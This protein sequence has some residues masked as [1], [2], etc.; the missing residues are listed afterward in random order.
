MFPGVGVFNIV[1]W[2]WTILRAVNPRYWVM[3]LVNEGTHG[4][5]LLG[6]IVLCITGSPHN[7]KKKKKH[8][9]WFPHNMHPEP[10]LVVV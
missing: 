10:T 7:A 9:L 1:H 2:D 4:W 3:F 8:N 6:S 5:H